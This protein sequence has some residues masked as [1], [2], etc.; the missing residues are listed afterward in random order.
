[1]RPMAI[2]CWDYESHL[3]GLGCGRSFYQ[4]GPPSWVA[5]LLSANAGLRLGAIVLA[6]EPDLSSLKLH[7]G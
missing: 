4:L 1:M 2:Y 3:Y 7:S 5:L 6:D